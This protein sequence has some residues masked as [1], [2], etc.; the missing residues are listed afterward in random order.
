[1]KITALNYNVS[2]RNLSRLFL[3][4][5]FIIILA[6]Y[7]SGNAI[8]Q[9]YTSN[10]ID[11]KTFTTLNNHENIDSNVELNRHNA[12]QVVIIELLSAAS[13]QLSGI[14]PLNQNGKCLGLNPSTGKLGYVEKNGGAIAV[15]GSLINATFTKPASGIQYMA[16]LE[17]NFDIAKNS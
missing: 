14:D 13:C 11:Y 8:A 17:N 1:M 16:Y 15:V 6:T 4:I 9:E 2:L 7:F 12:V 3:S 5:S 10:E